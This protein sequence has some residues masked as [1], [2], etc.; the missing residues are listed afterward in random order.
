MSKDRTKSGERSDQRHS[1][2]PLSIGLIG[3]TGY[4]ES[5]FS[6]LQPIVRSGRLRWGAVT[7]INP[8]EAPKQVEYFQ[9]EGVPI[10]RDYL[11]MLDAEKDR[12]D[13]VAIPTGIGWHR[14]MTIDCLD[15]GLP[16]LVEKPVAPTLQ[17]IQLMQEVQERSGL[18]V[19]VGYQHIYQDEVRE[20]KKHL[21]DGAIGEI[22]EIDAFALWPRAKSYYS[23]NRWSGCLHDGHSW[24]LDS[25][26]HNANAHISNLVLFFAG[27]TQNGRGHMK[28]LRSETYRCKPISSFDTVRAEVE[29]KEGIV[30]RMTF[31]HSCVGQVDPGIRITGTKGSLIWRFCNVHTLQNASG[32][33]TFTGRDHHPMRDYMLEQLV[34]YFEGKPVDVVT[35]DQAAGVSALVNAIHDTGPIHDIPKSS[36][37]HLKM[38]LG[39]ELDA[40]E[41]MEYYGVRAFV[42]GKS[43][44]ELG[45]PW[46]A[47][48]SERDVSSYTAFEGKYSPYPLPPIP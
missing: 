6:S 28:T 26:M 4:G 36:V 35:I 33:K 19:A 20:I 27:N 39:D 10:Y 8:E 40:I 48:L 11:E 2:G 42:E 29:F 43:F 15:R 46:A 12:L 14:K 17:D 41:N 7:I 44:K 21:L 22:R 5:Y 16:V 34:D 1:G 9:S 13:W 18:Q 45:A 30:G 47:E 3:V 32:E 38:P 24:I 25:P 31:S 37:S 23:R